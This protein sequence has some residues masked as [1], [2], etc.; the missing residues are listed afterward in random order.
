[1]PE[2][3]ITLSGRAA[4]FPQNIGVGERTLEI[5]VVDGATG[6][7]KGE[8]PAPRSTSPGRRVG[9][10]RGL[11]SRQA[12]RVRPASTR[13]Q[14]THHLYYEPFTRSDHLV[15]LLTSSPAAG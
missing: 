12:L 1:M 15:R 9:P 5:W 4:L 10:V 7:R 11:R 14:I 6:Q 3:R 2:R 13:E 8:R